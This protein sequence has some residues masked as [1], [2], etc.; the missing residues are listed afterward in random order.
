MTKSSKYYPY[1][2]VINVEQD[3]ED[4]YVKLFA[5]SS[6]NTT[7]FS[8]STAYKVK[9]YKIQDNNP[10]LNTKRSSPS[11][12]ASALEANAEL[13]E[14]SIPKISGVK[15]TGYNQLIKVG[16]SE[17]GEIS[18]VITLDESTEVQN[19][20]DSKL[21]RFKGMNPDAK[22]YVTSSSVK[23]SSTGT[24][25]Y[26]LKSSTPLF[27]IPKDRTDESGYSLKSAITGNSMVSGGTYY[28]DA[29]DLSSTKYPD[30]LLVYNTTFKSGTAITYSTAYRLL[31]DDIEEELRD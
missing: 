11:S 23:E 18:D 15:G 13:P 20:D 10:K 25:Y 24:T 29:Y 3:G 21:V 22:Y 17:A 28:L 6:T 12:I 2:Y 7:S 14:E 30:A 4:Y 9:S 1:A 16:F 27:V 26:S 8:S 31:G 19:E 5:P